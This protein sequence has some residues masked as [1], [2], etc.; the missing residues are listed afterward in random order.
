MKENRPNYEP[1]NLV[2][3]VS[4]SGG[5]VTRRRGKLDE[6]TDDSNHSVRLIK[7]EDN[8]S[9]EKHTDEC[10]K[11]KTHITI[12]DNKNNN[13]NNN[14]E[15]K[16][17]STIM[18]T[19]LND[20][21]G[22]PYDAIADIAANSHLR[23]ATAIA[24]PTTAHNTKTAQTETACDSVATSSAITASMPRSHQQQPT[25][26]TASMS[27]HYVPPRL[28]RD[29]SLTISSS[30]RKYKHSRNFSGGSGGG[31]KEASSATGDTTTA[32]A[33]TM[34]LKEPQPS[35]TSDQHK[36]FVT[37]IFEIGMKNCS[38][39]I[40]MENMRKQP[41]Y[42]TRERTKSHLQ[43]YR[44]TKE[45]SRNEFLK[46][47]DAFF[48]STEQVKIDLVTTQKKS[49]SSPTPDQDQDQSN[50]IDNKNQQQNNTKEPIPKAVL[51]AALDGKKPSKLLGGRAAALLSYS[52]MNNF[53]TDYGPDQLQYKAAKLQ[54]FPI[55][56]EEE[57]RTSVGSS[58]LQVKSLLDNMTDA[59]LKSRH[60]IKPL[61]RDAKGIKDED[62]VASSIMSSD[63]GYSD[64]DDDCGDVGMDGK[65]D[66]RSLA[67]A[68]SHS[69]DQDSTATA[70]NRRRPPF[71]LGVGSSHPSLP[72]V[73]SGFPPQPYSHAHPHA[74]QSFYGG[75]P[76]AAALAPGGAPPGYGPTSFH[77]ST[78][79]Y[80]QDP[81][82][83]PYQQPPAGSYPIAP[84]QATYYPS[85][86]TTA[87]YP[88]Y[89][90]GTSVEY[91]PHAAS[92]ASVDPYYGQ[93]LRS[94]GP[95]TGNIGHQQRQP[96]YGNDA[97]WHAGGRPYEMFDMAD[98]SPNNNKISGRRAEK[99]AKRRRDRSRH[100]E[101][102][103]LGIDAAVTSS[104]RSKN[105][106]FMDRVSKV[107]SPTK[108]SR[109]TSATPLRSRKHRRTPSSS[110]VS[111]TSSSSINND[112][113]TGRFV[114]S[115]ETYTN[116]FGSPADP[117]SEGE[118]SHFVASPY[119][120][121]VHAQH[122]SSSPADPF[123]EGELS[124]FVA[125][126]YTSPIHAAAK[127]ARNRQHNPN[128]QMWGEPTSFMDAGF[129]DQQQLNQGGGF[130]QHQQQK[131]QLQLQLQLQQPD[132]TSI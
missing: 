96:V 59:L 12:G 127:E 98:G 7:V 115:S 76:P 85:V 24:I 35:W 75:G 28:H 33:V 54:E 91:P 122:V 61:S 69:K 4:I 124:H 30:N 14:D 32:D 16:L 22:D 13:S 90:D 92:A 123:S 102:P 58:L 128:S 9:V 114:V 20:D 62:S 64:D 131:L 104:S 106:D 72:P 108:L 26:V 113:S 19:M 126:P 130:E 31:D 57:K 95:S 52:V 41:R 74:P 2:L 110:S 67:I 94:V 38:P 60:G 83:N 27:N 46:D 5:G 78:M 49:S 6:M 44:Q 39:S 47:Y 70:T 93:Q 80:T 8:N 11:G 25:I 40:I 82:L 65:D 45:R 88:A 132:H 23:A 120:G 68:H 99:R 1:S 21:D 97:Q 42:I 103:S 18:S 105:F 34:P 15:T 129:N 66:K 17:P 55:M 111:S 118:L 119:N 79:H 121:T 29:G 48:K 117:F 56:T 10:A 86:A 73:P 109:R 50:N 81:R 112:N 36:A 84:S 71:G 53:S 3:V 63:D 87:G 107:P 116:N 125:S 100:S 43:K 37:A 101:K 77:P 51:T 89:Y